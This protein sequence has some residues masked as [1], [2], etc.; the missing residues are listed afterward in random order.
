M[1]EN[2]MADK[3]IAWACGEE[4][5]L[6]GDAS[7]MLGV[8]YATMSRLIKKN[9][10]TVRQIPGHCRVWV[11]RADVER[12]AEMAVSKSPATA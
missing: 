9:G 6:K 11:R 5:V 3:S 12:L 7:R 8:S 10:V 1:H 4:Y 2:S